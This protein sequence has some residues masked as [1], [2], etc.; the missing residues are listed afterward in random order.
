MND[1]KQ[2]LKVIEQ[3][4]KS[5]SFPK[6]DIYFE[7]LRYLVKEEKEGRN[8]KSSTI[9][10]DLFSSDYKNGISRD[11]YVR[12]K[13]LSLR[14][15]LKQFYLSEGVHYGTQL[16][17]PKGEYKLKLNTIAQEP[18][19]RQSTNVLSQF[20]GVLSLWFVF[21]TVILSLLFAC[22][23]YLFIP[24]V[25]HEQ[26]PRS[27]VSLFLPSDKALDI[28]YGDRGFY[29]EYEPR[30]KRFR[31]IYDSE[32]RLPHNFL[33]LDELKKKL[34][35]RKIFFDH[36]FYHT[37]IGNIYLLSDIK[38]EWMLNDQ[39][40]HLIA[41]S[42]KKEIRHNTLF[43]SKTTSGDMYKVFSHYFRRSKAVLSG[44]QTKWSY[45]SS[46]ALGDTILHFN[47]IRMKYQGEYY[48]RSFCL[49]KKVITQQGHE[50]LFLLPTN[51]DARTYISKRLYDS[52]F[53]EE[54]LE[55][56]EGD[57]PQEF[58]L[59]FEILS[60]ASEGKLHK[61]AHNSYTGKG[62]MF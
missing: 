58:E 47:T 54:I 13:M 61:I 38:A 28:V 36:K 29:H 26:K 7:L 14:K 20:K 32:V 23:F 60:F 55:S 30:L 11:S 52:A 12:S 3:L 16:S 17:I 25:A 15:D 22:L 46:Y 41:S 53:Q 8:V 6:Q 49:I 9:A 56:F 40:V 39:K 24:L 1:S 33:R 10:I 4:E 19:K 50:L 5:N 35:E 62:D 27:F 18:V 51:D 42:E 37:D 44:G 45:I 31:A 57:V 2:K 34:P 48:S 21:S 43:L 59:L